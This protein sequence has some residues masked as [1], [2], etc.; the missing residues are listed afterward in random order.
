MECLDI[1]K[2]HFW[3]FPYDRTDPIIDGNGMNTG[4]KRVV[5]HDGAELWGNISPASGSSYLELFGKAV[6]YDKSIILSGTDYPI[7]EHTVL[8]VDKQPEYDGNGNLLYDY[9]IRRV[10]KSLNTTAIAIAKV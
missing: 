8:C 3:C 7:D 6:Q 10:S 5:Y 9:V 1:N 4:A 2:T